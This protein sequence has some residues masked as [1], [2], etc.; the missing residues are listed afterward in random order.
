MKKFEEIEKKLASDH[1]LEI[2]AD[3]MI[4]AWINEGNSFAEL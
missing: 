1:N 4:D 2:Y 3:D